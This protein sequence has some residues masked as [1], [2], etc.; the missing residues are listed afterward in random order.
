MSRSILI[1][2][3][4]CWVYCYGLRYIYVIY[5]YFSSNICS[6]DVNLAK[7]IAIA[8]EI[9]SQNDEIVNYATYKPVETIF[10]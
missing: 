2:Y 4:S 5:I 1:N 10:I 3:Q 8:I 9:M 7:K 6:N